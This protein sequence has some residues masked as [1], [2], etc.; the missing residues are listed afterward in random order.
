[1]SKNKQ[2]CEYHKT[3]SFNLLAM[4]IIKSSVFYNIIYTWNNYKDKIYVY[5]WIYFLLQRGMC[6]W[7]YGTF[8]S[9]ICDEKQ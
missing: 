5:V 8:I 2:C 4:D 7:Y 6:V 9:K 3:Q 1:M